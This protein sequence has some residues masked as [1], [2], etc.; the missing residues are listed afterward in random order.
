MLG[1]E[2][3]VFRQK[4]GEQV[5]V[6]S[7]HTSVYGLAWLRQLAAAGKALDLGGNGYPNRYV[8]S[9][10]VLLPILGKALP[11]NASPPVFGDDYVL[12]A[13]WSGAV[14][15]RDAARD[16]APEDQLMV[17]AWDQS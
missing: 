6:A 12:P 16:C 17:E 7:W 2:V 11:E 10:G 3:M 9:A 1:W 15:W 13:G 14:S 5:L 4:G 8:V